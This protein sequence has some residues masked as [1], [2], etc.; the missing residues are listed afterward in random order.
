MLN[1]K[2]EKASCHCRAEPIRYC[3]LFLESYWSFTFF[4]SSL[5][6]PQ[7]IQHVKNLITD[8]RAA[9]SSVWLTQSARLPTLPSL[10]PVHIAARHTRGSWHCTW[11]EAT[12]LWAVAH[13]MCS[14][15]MHCG[16][17]DILHPCR[18]P[19][20]VEAGSKDSPSSVCSHEITI[21]MRFRK[22]LNIHAVKRHFPVMLTGTDTATAINLHVPGWKLIMG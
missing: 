9:H 12:C 6:A 21:V 11:G 22:R 1:Q 13:Q 2:Q 7:P 5:F 8:T 17:S 20:L 3:F 10:S 16:N 19:D 18:D 14:G 4:S 15:M